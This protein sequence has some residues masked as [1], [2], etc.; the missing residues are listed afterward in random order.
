MQPSHGGEA[1]QPHCHHES[2]V[3]LINSASQD[4]LE[5]QD[6][7]EDEK[8]ELEDEKLSLEDEKL[9]LENEEDEL[10]KDDEL[11][12]KELE[13]EDE[14]EVLTISTSIS[15]IWSS[16]KAGLSVPSQ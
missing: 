15:E 16:P 9:L 1:S 7:Q 11:L 12:E 6:E 4:E 2:V 13:L 3:L 8:D 10:E 14:D 5:E